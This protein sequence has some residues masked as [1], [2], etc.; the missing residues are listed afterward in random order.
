MMVREGLLPLCLLTAALTPGFVGAAPSHD[1]FTRAADAG[2]DAL[3]PQQEK[4]AFVAAAAVPGRT[5]DATGRPVP[6][7]TLAA[8]QK[9]LASVKQ[10]TLSPLEKDFILVVMN[11]PAQGAGAF[12]TRE[13]LI[14]HFASAGVSLGAPGGEGFAGNDLWR[15]VRAARA[16]AE[17][18]RIPP[19]ILLCL[20]FR[21]SSF[22]RS[23]S[24][25]TT[26]AKG[27]AQMTN[28]AVADTIIL[29]K[30]DQ[31]LR[32]DTENYAR[33]LGATMPTAVVGAPDVDALTRELGLLSKSK[34]PAVDISKKKLERQK[35]IA[36]H[37]DE[38]GHIYNIET[39][40]GLAA[41][42]LA[43]LRHRLAEVKEERK[44][45]LTTVAAYNQG[46]GY[47]NALIYDVFAGADDFNRQSLDAVFSVAAAAKLKLTPQRQ[48]EMLSEVGSV[49]ACAC[50]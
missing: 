42:Y 11:L 1:D 36:S 30:R 50:P 41:A 14:A 33:A 13:Q 49:R 25:W 32:T 44:A 24:A 18:Y 39:N 48:A 37:K 27:L 31:T 40:F 10:R 8:Y 35:A 17:A 23:A 21:E 29:I 6:A 16:A 22:E 19:A 43:G 2:I 15:L 28:G 20:T 7:E 3:R 5:I 38:P 4:V 26:S 34:A 46:L 12:A 9:V 47:A 45:W